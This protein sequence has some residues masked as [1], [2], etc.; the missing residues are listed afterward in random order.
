MTTPLWRQDFKLKKM[1]EQ[2]PAA[3]TA[4]DRACK[5]LAPATITIIM[6][7]CR[8]VMGNH[9]GRAQ[10]RPAFKAAIPARRQ[11]SSMGKIVERIR[12]VEVDYLA[13]WRVSSPGRLV[14]RVTAREAMAAIHHNSTVTVA[15]THSKAMADN[16]AI[17]P[18][19]A[20]VA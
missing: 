8:R 4:Q 16:M 6:L 10:S 18:G 3:D 19:M 15:A 2:E 12:V 7:R 9:M 17:S 13:N 11:V 5:I 14:A 20:V 1:P